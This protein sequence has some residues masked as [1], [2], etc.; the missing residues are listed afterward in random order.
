MKRFAVLL[1]LLLACGA[2][3]PVRDSAS[4]LRCPME[5]AIPRLDAMARGCT[6]TPLEYVDTAG[7]H[8]YYWCKE[9][10]TVPR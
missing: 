10:I 2:D 3:A 7:V 6:W 8:R 5:I 4:E 9:W 1:L